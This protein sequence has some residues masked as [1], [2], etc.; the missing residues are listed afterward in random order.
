MSGDAIGPDGTVRLRFYLAHANV[1]RFAAGCTACGHQAPIGARPAIGLM[2]SGE[3]TVGQLERR[4]RCTGEGRA[5]LGGCDSGD[6]AAATRLDRNA[7]PRRPAL[8]PSEVSALVS[9]IEL[10]ASDWR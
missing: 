1:H 5:R 6:G 10:A 4:L 3:A 2:G 7:P 9:R 8:A